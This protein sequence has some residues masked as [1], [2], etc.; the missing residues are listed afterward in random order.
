MERLTIRNERGGYTVKKLRAAI[1]KLAE[2]ET[3]EESGRLVILPGPDH[4]DA[5]GEK[6]ETP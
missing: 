2:Y 3:L 4:A 6:G 1:L 5:D